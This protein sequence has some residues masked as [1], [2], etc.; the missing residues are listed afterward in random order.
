[1]RSQLDYARD[2]GLLWDKVHSLFDTDVKLNGEIK[3][4][5]WLGNLLRGADGWSAMSED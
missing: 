1:M 2:A 5:S 4:G 3:E